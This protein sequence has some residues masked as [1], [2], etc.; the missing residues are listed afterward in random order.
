MTRDLVHLRGDPIGV[1][2]FPLLNPQQQVV[3]LRVAR[4]FATLECGVASCESANSRAKSRISAALRPMRS[5]PCPSLAGYPPAV[6][7]QCSALSFEQS[8]YHRGDFVRSRCRAFRCSCAKDRDPV[9]TV[10]ASESAA[11]RN[12]PKTGLLRLTRSPVVRMPSIGGAENGP[13]FSNSPLQL[14]IDEDRFLLIHVPDRASRECEDPQRG[15]R[16]HGCGQE[17]RSTE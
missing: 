17:G 13:Y 12:G 10:S 6:P 9:L 5:W 11:S 8:A 15:A 2:L 3:D 4:R 16:H 7:V 1:R 14:L